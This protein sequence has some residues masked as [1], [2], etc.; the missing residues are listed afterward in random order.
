MNAATVAGTFKARLL[1]GKQRPIFASM[2]R[3]SLVLGLLVLVTA[4]AAVLASRGGGSRRES[5]HGRSQIG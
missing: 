4:A 1:R 3:R 5:A 2:L